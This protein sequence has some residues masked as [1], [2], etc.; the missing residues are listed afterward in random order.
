MHFATFSLTLIQICKQRS[1]TP[2]IPKNIKYFTTISHVAEVVYCLTKRQIQTL[3]TDYMRH[4]LYQNP[5]IHQETLLPL[6]CLQ[7]TCSVNRAVRHTVRF[8]CV[9]KTAPQF[10]AIRHCVWAGAPGV[11][12]VCFYPA[13][14]LLSTLFPSFQ[15]WQALVSSL[16]LST[17]HPSPTERNTMLHSQLHIYYPLLSSAHGENGCC[18]LY[19]V[20]FSLY[21]ADFHFCVYH[22][23]LV[24]VGSG[25]KLVLQLA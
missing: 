14:K 11:L 2:T 8:V 18:F 6:L 25:S 23:H 5:N 17:I 13:V 19:I 20:C 21:L 22:P 1:N 9:L 10:T 12:C 16:T 7:K 4:T 15:H 3:E 24:G